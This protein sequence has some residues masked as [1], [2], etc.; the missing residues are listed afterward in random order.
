MLLLENASHSLECTR[1][2]NK[3]VSNQ[4]T[5]PGIERRICKLISRAVI[6]EDEFA[7]DHVGLQS[8][9]LSWDHTR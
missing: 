4:G 6:D 1:T 8:L 3:V 5:Y 2:G 7:S 9:C